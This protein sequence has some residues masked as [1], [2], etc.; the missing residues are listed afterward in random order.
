M[1]EFQ[2]QIDVSVFEANIMRN[3]R[4]IRA[5]AF[6]PMTTKESKKLL[7]S[8]MNNEVGLGLGLGLGL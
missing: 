5:T 2:I 1:R 8:V 4:A 6:Q 7:W 3:D